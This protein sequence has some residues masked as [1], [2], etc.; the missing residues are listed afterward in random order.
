MQPRM[1]SSAVTEPANAACAHDDLD[2]GSRFVQERRRFDRALPGA[3]HHEALTGK[4]TQIV[5][6]RRVRSEFI[7]NAIELGRA[8]CEGT[9]PTCD[10]DPPH[11]ETRTVVEQQSKVFVTSFD[12]N[13]ATMI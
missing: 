3:H 4:A 5:M 11:G 1:Q 10:H 13:D 8:S 12:P 9:Q 2:C 6:F 7:A